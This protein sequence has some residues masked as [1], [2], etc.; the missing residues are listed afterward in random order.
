MISVL[1]WIKIRFKEKS[2]YAGI[3]FISAMIGIKFTPEKYDILVAAFM[4]IIAA[5][6]MFRKEGDKENSQPSQ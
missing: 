5:W 1:K 6:E 4:A 3:A 2:T